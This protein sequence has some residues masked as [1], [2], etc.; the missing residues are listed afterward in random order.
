MKKSKTSSIYTSVK[1][2]IWCFDTI[3]NKKQFSRRSARPHRYTSSVDF[4]WGFLKGIIQARLCP[5]KESGPLTLP[6]HRLMCLKATTAIQACPKNT[7]LSF[8]RLVLPGNSWSAENGWKCSAGAEPTSKP[9]VCSTLIFTPRFFTCI[10]YRRF[11]RQLCQ[12]IR[13]LPFTNQ[14]RLV[15]SG[16]FKL[17]FKLGGLRTLFQPVRYKHRTGKDHRWSPSLPWPHS[18]AGLIIFVV[19]VRC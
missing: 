5:R 18:N 11:L 12:S 8:S 3:Q 14:F 19:H 16:H 9:L 4:G 7:A 13:N 6:S 10:S 15:S 2:V 17:V 1:L